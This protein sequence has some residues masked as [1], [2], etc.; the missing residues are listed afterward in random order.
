MELA[1]LNLIGCGRTISK[2]LGY[3]VVV[4]SSPRQV[5]NNVFIR[6]L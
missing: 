5:E 2:M 4:V 1:I 3:W 6:I